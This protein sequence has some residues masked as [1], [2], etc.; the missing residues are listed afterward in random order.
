MNE[1][2][3]LRRSGAENRRFGVGYLRLDRFR[4]Y[5]RLDLELDSGFNVL[6]GPNAQGKTNL[7]EG[8]ALL[9]T[10]RMLRGQKDAEAIQEGFES[11]RVEGDLLQSHTTL[12]VALERGSRK[13]VFVNSLGL[14]RASDIL[15]RL[16][17]VQL[18]TEDMAIAR[19]EPS[20]RRLFLD[21]DL[22]S[23]YPAYLHHLSLYKRALEQRNALLKQ[24][25]H[26]FVED[27]AFEP[28]EEHLALHGVAL[29]SL[30]LQYLEA[31]QEPA[32]AVHSLMGDG[33]S[34]SLKY[35]AKDDALT[36]A[37]A[38]ETLAQN[39]AQ[40]VHRGSTSI[41]PHR[42]DLLIEVGE[43]EARLFGSQGQQRT[44]VIAI[45]LA[46]LK[47]ASRELGAPPMLLLDDILSD[48]DER[49]RAH[50]IEA[51]LEGA[52]QAVLTCTEASAAGK[53]ILEQARIFSVCAG[54]VE[55]L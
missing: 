47:V 45:K 44:A 50:L 6:A 46:A 30:R 49:R 42:D 21:L 55:R 17:S 36:L 35:S 24:A 26:H 15:G 48:L 12:A 11:M 3:T 18:T 13:R 34:L 25:Q 31:L 7:L 10:A 22:S 43:R 29:R 19:G 51:V 54:K 37:A 33:E 16:P 41:G 9:S 1:E 4:N 32:V 8:L 52:G 2:E 40:D 38:Q 23:L 20:D 39:R 5:E 14:P 53:R 28:W 27:F